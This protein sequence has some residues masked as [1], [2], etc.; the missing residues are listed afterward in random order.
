LTCTT[1]NIAP[2]VRGDTRKIEI[3]ITD[4]FGVPVNIQGHTIFFTLKT[5]KTLADSLAMLQVSYTVATDADA[6]VGK[7]VLVLSATDTAS[8]PPGKYFYDIQWVTTGATVEVTTIAI[9]ILSVDYDI[10]VNII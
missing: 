1:S 9:G 5:D 2:L 6:L 4:E 3:T 10:T 7:T 8:V